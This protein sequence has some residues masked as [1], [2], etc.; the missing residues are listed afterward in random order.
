[1][2]ATGSGCQFSECR[3]PARRTTSCRPGRQRR[4]P[5]RSPTWATDAEAGQW[6][7]KQAGTGSG[8]HV[9]VLDGPPEEPQAAVLE[10][11]LQPS[12]R[13]VRRPRRQQRE[14]VLIY[15]QA[16]AGPK[17]SPFKVC[18][19]MLA[20]MDI[21]SPPEYGREGSGVEQPPQ[22]RESV[23]AGAAQVKSRYRRHKCV[24]QQS[25]FCR[26]NLQV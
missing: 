18:K 17:C 5:P 22:W 4:I 15:L 3:W 1:M 23:A 6:G 11:R 12:P 8:F 7:R 20:G 25:G 26:P 16:A 21:R 14:R 2:K 10:R 13:P 24:H 19:S 9:P